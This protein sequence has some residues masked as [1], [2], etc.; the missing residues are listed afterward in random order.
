MPGAA[1][2]SFAPGPGTVIGAF[3]G[4]VA[5]GMSGKFFSNG[6]KLQGFKEAKAAYDSKIEGW[7]VAIERQWRVN[8]QGVSEIQKEHERAFNMHRA[9]LLAEAVRECGLHIGIY[10][11]A[12]TMTVQSLPTVYDD[13]TTQ[14]SEDYKKV[15]SGQ[16]SPTLLRRIFP[17]FSDHFYREAR[18]W[19]ARTLDT[20]RRE[21]TELTSSSQSTSDALAVWSRFSKQYRFSSPVLE[22]LMAKLGKE[23]DRVKNQLAVVRG[24]LENSVTVATERARKSSADEIESL[25]VRLAET[26]A[27]INSSIAAAKAALVREGKP[28]GI[29]I[30]ES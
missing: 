1:I 17:N 26:L 12:Y 18:G 11:S 23:H 3:I 22:A 13:I 8:E 10:S 24:K 2:G 16:S 29:I 20:I 27:P 6:I 28:V 21:R 5:G 4:S 9:A 19:F 7:N 15:F 25:C 14:L 30:P